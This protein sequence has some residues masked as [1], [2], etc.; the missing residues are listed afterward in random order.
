M[1]GARCGVFTV[2]GRLGIDSVFRA[3]TG[4]AR[5]G[6]A[7][8]AVIPFPLGMYLLWRV[9]GTS[10]ATYKPGGGIEPRQTDPPVHDGG[11]QRRLCQ[12]SDPA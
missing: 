9:K 10:P 12:S 4:R 7:G 11:E 8:F 2:G 1:G 3:R 5:T 6:R